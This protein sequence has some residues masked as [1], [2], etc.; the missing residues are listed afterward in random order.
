MEYPEEIDV[1]VSGQ[2]GYHTYRIPALIVTAEKTLLAFCE[3][4]RITGDDTDDIDVLVKRSIDGGDSWSEQQVV[5]GDAGN[6][7]GNPCPVVDEA[8][9]DIWL[10]GTWN[11]ID[12]PHET[13][14]A[15]TARFSR[16]PHITHSTDDGRTWAKASNIS[17]ATKHP[18]WRWYA[19]GPGVGI[20]LKH[21]PNQGRLV[22]P[23]NHSVPYPDNPEGYCG[24]IL[25]SDDH[26]QTWQNGGIIEGVNECQVAEL[27]DGRLLL[28]GR[29]H[30]PQGM[31]QKGVA[32]SVDGGLAWSPL[33][34]HPQLIEPVCQSSLIR[35]SWPEDGDKSRLLFSNPVNTVPRIV[36]K[37]MYRRRKLTVRLSY[38]EGETWPVAKLLEDG[39]SA[40]S[41]L[42]ALPNGDIACLHE[43]GGG[44]EKYRKRIVCKRFPLE[45]LTDGQDRH[46]RSAAR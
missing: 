24:H 20:Q 26:G 33:Q 28:H 40:Y 37:H 32:Y 36:N 31:H 6:T 2:D 8:T 12:E 15:G 5:W 1:F 16:Q 10:G 30:D 23:C 18:E 19:T 3:G 29:H 41:C 22:I 14:I 44:V 25:Y 46:P 34:F 43:G 45:W 35:Y 7:C 17:K 4:R 27:T 13:V 9:G 39:S 38:D 42:T 11:H 21:G